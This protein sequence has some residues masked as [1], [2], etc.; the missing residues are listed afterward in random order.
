VRALGITSEATEKGAWIVKEQGESVRE[1]LNQR[2]TEKALAS[3][4]GEKIEP[5][6]AAKEAREAFWKT[7][8]RRKRRPWK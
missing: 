8:R 2:S 1:Q 7:V 3:F 5:T 6:E 4:A